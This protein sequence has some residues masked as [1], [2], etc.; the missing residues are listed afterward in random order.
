[1]VGDPQGREDV[2]VEALLAQQKPV[3]DLEEF[4]GLCALDDPVIVGRGQGQHLAH[5]VFRDACRARALPFGGI[6]QGA[7]PDDGALALHEPRDRVDCPDASRIGQRDR[8][9]LEVRDRQFAVPGL[10]DDIFVGGPEVV[11]V[12]PFTALDPGHQQLTRAVGLGDIDGESD[13]DV[14]GAHEHGLSVLLGE[15]V[16]HLGHGLQGLDHRVPDEVGE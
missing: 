8:D 7:D 4:T 16:V 1:M 2:V 10:V 6:V 5:R 9:A 11:E 12:H 14:R 13:V 15:T 3:H